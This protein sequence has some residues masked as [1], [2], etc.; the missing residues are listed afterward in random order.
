M[1]TKFR[2]PLTESL[3]WLLLRVLLGYLGLAPT[4]IER[5]ILVDDFLVSGYICT[6]A[7]FR[8]ADGLLYTLAACTFM[9][10]C[11]SFK[12]KIQI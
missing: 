1:T 9:F 6:C 4:K 2:R 11:A 7:K 3:G 5:S 10:F 12:I 8:C